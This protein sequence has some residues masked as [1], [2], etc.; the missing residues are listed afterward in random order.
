MFSI[1]MNKNTPNGNILIANNHT[2]YVQLN[3]V[4]SW[5]KILINGNSTIKRDIPLEDI[6]NEI[7]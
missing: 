7:E 1:P 4:K 3:K 2:D 5:K 6:K